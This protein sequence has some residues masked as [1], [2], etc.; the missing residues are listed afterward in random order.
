MVAKSLL[1]YY[2]YFIYVQPGWQRSGDPK[3]K[4][5][6][7]HQRRWVQV[8]LATRIIQ[9]MNYA[10]HYSTAKCRG[11]AYV[12]LDLRAYKKGSNSER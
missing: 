3:T 4:L 2:G 5:Q 9:L 10:V 8:G 6:M 7:K 1:Q 12:A 11:N